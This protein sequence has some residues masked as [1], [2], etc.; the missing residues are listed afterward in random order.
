[1]TVG[2]QRGR[3]WR[4][5]ELQ[6]TGLGGSLA[7]THAVCLRP[8]ADPYPLM[9]INSFYNKPT[10]D[11]GLTVLRS[12]YI[13]LVQVGVAEGAAGGGG[14]DGGSWGEKAREERA[15]LRLQSLCSSRAPQK[16]GAVP[17]GGVR[18]QGFKAVRQ[19]TAN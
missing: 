9:R 12:S 13:Q 18:S 19:G 7:D 8:F 6:L 4:G 14:D 5:Y 11:Y 15:S 10:S 1:M 3:G 2:V 16:P 17:G